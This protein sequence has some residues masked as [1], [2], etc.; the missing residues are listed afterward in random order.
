MESHKSAPKLPQKLPPEVR[1]K[2]S[3]EFASIK[4]ANKNQNNLEA[5][6]N[7]YYYIEPIDQT[8]SF[9]PNETSDYSESFFNDSAYQPL[10]EVTNKN[11]DLSSS[12]LQTHS[13]YLDLNEFEED[14]ENEAKKSE[15]MEKFNENILINEMCSL[16]L[17]M[18]NQIIR[19]VS[20]PIFRNQTSSPATPPIPPKRMKT[21]SMNQQINVN[22]SKTESIYDGIYN[23]PSVLD[24]SLGLRYSLGKFKS[25]ISF[26]I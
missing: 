24:D 5:Q 12:S 4:S 15:N 8:Q 17:D 2:L 18:N 13:F 23:Q 10:V 7:A 3:I 22:R 20:Q 21:P 26:R 16:K 25:Q 6:Q 19:P 14:R 11:D 9:K 1:K